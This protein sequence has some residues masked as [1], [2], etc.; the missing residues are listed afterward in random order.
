MGKIMVKSFKLESSFTRLSMTRPN[1]HNVWY[2]VPQIV[3]RW[4][5]PV[6]SMITRIFEVC[7]PVHNTYRDDWTRAPVVLSVMNSIW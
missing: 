7:M 4:Q 2:R 1:I 5:Q 3:C 6:E